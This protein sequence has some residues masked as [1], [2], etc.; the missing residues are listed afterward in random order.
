MSVAQLDEIL[1][2]AEV[3]DKFSEQLFH[4]LEQGLKENGYNLTPGDIETLKA[5]LSGCGTESAAA[6]ATP[7]GAPDRTAPRPPGPQ[8]PSS[9][10]AIVDSIKM[11]Q[12]QTNKRSE[13]QS[14]R[15]IELG[16]H[17]VEIFENTLKYSARTYRS[18]TIMNAVMFWMGVVLFLFAAFYGAFTH[19]AIVTIAFGGLGAASFIA[20][21]FLG[22]IEKTQA[23]LS[24]LIQAEIAFMSYYEQI[25]FA[26]NYAMLPPPGSGRPSHD[27]IAKASEMLQKRSRETIELLQI[28]VGHTP[29]VPKGDEL[30]GGGKAHAK[31]ENTASSGSAAG[32][33]AGAVS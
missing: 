6:G 16:E 20:L 11:Q 15:M 19:N 30:N 33:S 2:R 32:A 12:A 3:D 24:S 27:N 7:P 29:S 10:D 14:D 5:R 23:A 4:N 18:V 25:T 31:P 28:Y 9:V 1:H 26:E 13:A 8:G 22:P 17:T 21:F